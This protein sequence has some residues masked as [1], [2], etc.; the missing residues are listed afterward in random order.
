MTLNWLSNNKIFKQQIGQDL[1]ILWFKEKE[2]RR[3]EG[4][5]RRREEE[6]G[7]KREEEGWGE[8]GRR[9]EEDGRRREEEEGTGRREGGGKREDGGMEEDG[10]AG[11]RREEEGRREEDA[12]VVIR[13]LPSNF[14]G[15]LIRN[16]INDLLL[17][18]VDLDWVEDP[19]YFKGQIA[20]IVTIGSV[21]QAENLIRIMNHMTLQERYVLKVITKQKKRR[22]RVNGGRREEGG[23]REEVGREGGRK[24]GCGNEIK[25]YFLYIKVREEKEEGGGRREEIREK[26]I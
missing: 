5:G 25:N 2:I 13:N 19:F 9:R 10:G 14:N 22:R 3:R 17:D 16:I 11:R 20:T 18:K 12:Q 7:R 21:K 26:G 15:G 8:D 23:G 6:D 1:K 24:E 4:E